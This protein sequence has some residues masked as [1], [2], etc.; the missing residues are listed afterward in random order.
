MR[1]IELRGAGIFI[2]LGH[3]VNEMRVAFSLYFS[4]TWPSPLF[5]VFYR[6]HTRTAP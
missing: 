4:E 3:L 1:D 2:S 6:R 5:D